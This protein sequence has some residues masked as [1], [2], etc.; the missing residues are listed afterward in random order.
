VPLRLAVRDI[1]QLQFR[2]V[3]EPFVR[4]TRF[5]LVYFLPADPTTM[6]QCASWA[7]RNS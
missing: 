1:G 3:A 7:T 4:D 5:R 2:L 6:R